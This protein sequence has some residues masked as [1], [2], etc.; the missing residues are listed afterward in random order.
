MAREMLDVGFQISGFGYL[1]PGTSLL[2]LGFVFRAPDL[3]VWNLGGRVPS[4]G[5]ANEALPLSRVP[6][7]RPLAFHLDTRSLSPDIRNVFFGF[8]GCAGPAVSPFLFRGQE[9][10]VGVEG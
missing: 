9:L 7:R 4:P 1:D 6:V 3:G 2:F 10:G 8:R 5:G